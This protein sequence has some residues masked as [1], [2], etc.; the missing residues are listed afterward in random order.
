MAR[1]LKGGEV[2]DSLSKRISQRVE[3]LKKN[4]IFPTLAIVR[5]GE[6]PE[7]MSYERGAM[8]RAVQLGITVRQFV[9]DE[10]TSQ[11]ELLSEI[12]KLNDDEHIHGVLIF[13]PLPDHIDDRAVCDALDPQKD[14]D[15]ITSGSMAGVFMDRDDGF[16]PCTAE[17]C[18]ELLQHYGYALEGKRI[19]VI[20]RS[21]VIGRPVA[22]MAMERNATVTICHSRTGD[23]ALADI[24]GSADIVIAAVGS[25]G[26]VS[27]SILGHDQVI[28]DVGINVDENGSLCGDVD[29]KTAEQNAAAITPV[30]GGVG[31]VTTAVLMKH[32][33][34]A[35][36]R[37]LR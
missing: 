36:E 24:V 19:A 15:G 28:V 18:L 8:K 12:G 3:E 34:T 6:K 5:L 35:A 29:F 17:A 22:M 10:K 33:V 31:S 1:K 21:L 7:D 32:V 14:V 11:E 13:R 27:G 20:G 9:F 37:S 25:A 26:M 4:G 2:S 30:P 16:P 23:E